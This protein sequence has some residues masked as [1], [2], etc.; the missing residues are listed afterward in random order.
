[1][2]RILSCT[3]K[4]LLCF[5]VNCTLKVLYIDCEPAYVR[6]EEESELLLKKTS[7][8]GK[9][10]KGSLVLCFIKSNVSQRQILERQNLDESVC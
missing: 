6:R 10:K 2:I 8:S 5:A 7:L 4:D 1:M 3:H 9:G